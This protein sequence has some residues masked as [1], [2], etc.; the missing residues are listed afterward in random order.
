MDEDKNNRLRNVSTRVW[1]HPAEGRYVH[2]ADLTLT[3]YQL[4]WSSESI[5]YLEGLSRAIAKETK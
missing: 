4:N 2:L 3:A 1:D 5:E